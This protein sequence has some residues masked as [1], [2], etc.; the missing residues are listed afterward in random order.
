[1]LE[2]YAPLHELLFGVI[3]RDGT[4]VRF[5]LQGGRQM[6]NRSSYPTTIYGIMAEME[7]YLIAITAYRDCIKLRRERGDEVCWNCPITGS[8]IP[9]PNDLCNLTEE[10]RELKIDQHLD[11][12]CRISNRQYHS[13]CQRVNEN[14]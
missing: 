9:Y 11:Q 5:D 13:S 1:L 6:T 7:S 3:G 8:G 12:L 10:E 14:E 4:L 2:K